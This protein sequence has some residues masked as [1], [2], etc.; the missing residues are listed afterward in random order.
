[1][2]MTL[3]QTRAQLLSGALTKGEYAAQMHRLHERLFEYASF[4][5]NTDIASI[6]ISDGKVV[7]TTRELGLRFQ[8]DP[9]DQ[10]TT[11]LTILNFG[12][13]EAAEDHLVRELVPPN[14]TVLDIGANVGW[15]ALSIA[16]RF[17]RSRVFA[18]EPLPNTFSY[19]SKNVALNQLANIECLNMGLFDKEQDLTFFFEPEITGRAS[20][21]NLAERENVERIVC[22][23]RRLDDWVA[24]RH[25]RVDFI[26]CDCEGAEL[27]V[28]RGGLHTLETDHPAIFAEMLR[29]WSAKFGYQPNEIIALLGGIGYGCYA[30]RNGRLAPFASMTDETVE[31]NFFFLHPVRHAVDI[32][33]LSG[34]SGF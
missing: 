10:H 15:Y 33:R 19:L 17:P 8:C 23:V 31:T 29:K 21:A 26:K 18:F 20:A 1:M 9:I 27:F 14:A 4:L 13:Y 3:H 24:E 2:S 16:K 34:A 30:V 11:P 12:H 25:L 6:E 32:Q 5:G 7:L 22:H 28:F